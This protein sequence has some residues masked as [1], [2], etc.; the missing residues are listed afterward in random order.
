MGIIE[1]KER[2]KEQRKEEIINAA[3]RIFQEKGLSA[4]TM[5]EI[6]EAAELGKST[7]YLYYKSKEDLYLVVTCRGGDILHS[8]F[9][10]AA[11]TDEPSVKQIQNIGDAYINYFNQHRKY[12]RMYYFLE[13][14]ELHKQVSPEMADLCAQNDKRIWGIVFDTIKRAKED[15]YLKEDV[16]PPEAAVM[17]WACAYGLM[18]QIDRAEDMW[19]EQ[20]GVELTTACKKAMALLLEGMMTDKGKRVYE[21]LNM[22]RVNN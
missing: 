16:H 2:E 13:N 9:L 12:Y 17:F 6:A 19:R 11:G 3:E 7:L 8:M 1:R 15:G 10:E 22:S 4:T 21:E 5:D 18:R 14:S 20:M